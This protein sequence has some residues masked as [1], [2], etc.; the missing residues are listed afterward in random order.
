MPG[1]PLQLESDGLFRQ[2]LISVVTG[3]FAADQGAET[4]VGV[5]DPPFDNDLFGRVLDDRVDIFEQL[6]FKG[7]VIERGIRF[8]LGVDS[9]NLPQH[10]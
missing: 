5:D 8:L 7:V 2:P 1:H 9:G 6:F 4:A 10:L 3:N